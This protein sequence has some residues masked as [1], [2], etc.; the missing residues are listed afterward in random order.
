MM[1][2]NVNDDGTET[3]G[4]SKLLK[5]EGLVVGLIATA[6]VVVELGAWVARLAGD[7][8]GPGPTLAV[9]AVTA[10]WLALAAGVFAASAQDGIG[11][12]LRGGTVADAS[13]VTLMMLWLFSPYVTFVSAV[14]IYLTLAAMALL[15][16]AVVNLPRAHWKRYAAAV[17]Y[18][19][20]MMLLLAT[21]FWIGG[22]L[23]LAGPGARQELTKWA[24][25]LNPFYCISAGIAKETAFVWHS[26]PILYTVT[27]IGDYAAPPPIAWY[28]CA[29]SYTAAAI[30]ITGCRWVLA[31][32]VAARS[33]CI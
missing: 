33:M 20:A 18:A 12:L 31:K 11:S 17:A 3:L 5:R 13:V 6:T 1:A 15:A 28:W 23:R 26:A 22:L 16:I 8:P 4:L 14:K 10:V 2:R 24:V 27:R 30:V 21:P 32:L 29:C 25:L 19:V 7:I 9:L